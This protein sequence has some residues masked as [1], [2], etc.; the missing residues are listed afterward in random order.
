VVLISSELDELME[1]SDRIG[2]MYNGQLVA[3][4]PRTEVDPEALGDLMLGGV[5]RPRRVPA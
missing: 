4:M 3:D 2:V 1:I 5:R